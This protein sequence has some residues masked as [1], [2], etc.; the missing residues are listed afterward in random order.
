MSFYHFHVRGP[1]FEFVDRE[2][3]VC[4]DDRQA[5]AQALWL[6]RET[7]LDAIEE[8]RAPR[9]ARIEV[10][11]RAGETLF[12]VP[13]AMSIPSAARATLARLADGARRRSDAHRH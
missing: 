13:I 8:E 5:H 6:A 4:R 2:G 7:L 12:I 11:D 1:G 10:T 3:A 9:G